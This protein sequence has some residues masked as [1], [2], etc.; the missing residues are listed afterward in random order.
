VEAVLD[1]NVRDV[2]IKKFLDSEVVTMHLLQTGFIERYLCWFAHGEPYVTHETMVE[3]MVWSIFSSSKVHGVVDDNSNPYK[4]M[5]MDAM[6]KNQGYV[7]QCL[8][9]D[10]EPNADMTRFFNLLKDS[11]RS[12]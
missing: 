7:D 10:E 4:N 11:D 5:I 3:M 8:I 12:L 2:K 1:V 9:I 6:R